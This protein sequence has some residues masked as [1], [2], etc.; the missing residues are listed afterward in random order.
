MNKIIL[1]INKKQTQEL[2]ALMEDEGYTSKTE[3]LR[4]LVKFFKYNR[5]QSD[6]FRLENAVNELAATVARL[7]EK[8][9]LDNLPS[10]EDQLADI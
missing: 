7:D 5:A 6:R 8:G 3:F 2:E 1:N 9:L 4:F 10:L